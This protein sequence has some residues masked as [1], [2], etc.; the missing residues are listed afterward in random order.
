ML[1]K[2]KKLIKP[3]THPNVIVASDGLM[4]NYQGHPRGAGTFPRLI[5]EYVKNKKTY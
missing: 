5:N 3:L 2:K 4:N 1:C